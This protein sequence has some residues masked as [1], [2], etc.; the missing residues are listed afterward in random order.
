MKFLICILFLTTFCVSNASLEPKVIADITKQA[1]EQ[2]AEPGGVFIIAGFSFDMHKYLSGLKD[3]GTKTQLKFNDVNAN[4]GISYTHSFKNNAFVGADIIFGLG[5][6]KT[7]KGSFKE[8][9]EDLDRQ[10]ASIAGDKT[11]KVESI[12][13]EVEMAVKGGY[14][15]LKYKLSVYGKIGLANIG[16]KYKYFLNSNQIAEIKMTKIVPCVALGTEY[17]LN[18]K[19]SANLEIKT[20]FKASVNKEINAT[21]YK[22]TG[23]KTSLRIYMKYKGA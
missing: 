17:R 15:F 22:I 16:I 3:G 11:V 23:E 19:F 8:M 9:N 14:S 7:K 1:I 20:V 5:K 4:T 10:Y 21:N 12:L 6:K 2:A 18:S 13:P